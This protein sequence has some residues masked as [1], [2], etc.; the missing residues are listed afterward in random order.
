MFNGRIFLDTITL[1]KAYDNL[2]IDYLKSYIISIETLKR[3][4]FGS[5]Y[6]ILNKLLTINK[7]CVECGHI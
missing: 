3:P 7:D 1:P 6:G 5:Y 2:A 4:F